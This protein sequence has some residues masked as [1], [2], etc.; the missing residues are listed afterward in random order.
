MFKERWMKTLLTALGVSTVLALPSQAAVDPTRPPAQPPYGVATTSIK[1][2]PWQLQAIR[3]SDQ[4]RHAVINGVRVRQGESVRGA[5]LVSIKPSAVVLKQGQRRI[6]LE[7]E[8]VINIKRSS[9]EA[10]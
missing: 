6:P 4:G 9:Q 10:E 7:L 1:A 5:E 8:S 3:I 2:S